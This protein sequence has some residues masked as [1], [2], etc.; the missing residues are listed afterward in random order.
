[1]AASPP[2]AS[3]SGSPASSSPRARASS[4]R[5]TTSG[6]R[7]RSGSIV[8]DA[9]RAASERGVT[10]RLIYNVDSGRPAALH[11]PP[12]TKPEILEELPIEVRAIA[13]VPDLMH[14]KYVVRDGEAVWTGSANWTI[15]SWSRQENVLAI[16]EAAG[17]GERFRKNFE[18]LWEGRNVERSGF[19][20]PDPVDVGGAEVRAWFTPGQGEDLSQ[21]IAHRDRRGARARPDRL[22]GDHLRPGPRDAGRAGGPQPRRRRGRRRRAAGRDGLQPVAR[23][24]PQRLEDPAARQ[25]ADR[26]GLHAPRPRPPG[27]PSRSSTTSCTAR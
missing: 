14:H 20:E 22:A 15:D 1:M 21:R 16:V 9:L 12:E 27:A 13:G 6:S 19:I 23:E 11:P 2:R 8:A 17:I 10:I 7:T 25:G 5:S 4:W 18:E 24:R 26:P 3:P